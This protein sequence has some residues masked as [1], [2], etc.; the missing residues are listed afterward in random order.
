MNQF[1][2]KWLAEYNAKRAKNHLSPINHID[3]LKESEKPAQ[4][5]PDMKKLWHNTHYEKPLNF[6]WVRGI[7]FVVP[8]LP[9]SKPRQTQSDKW[10]QRPCVMR[11]REFA[12]RV[13][14][15]IKLEDPLVCGLNLIF[16]IPVK[17]S[18]SKEKRDQMI[19]KPHQ[20]RP[21]IDNY[22]KAVMDAL[23][24][25]DSIVWSISA[26]KFWCE[27]GMEMIEVNVFY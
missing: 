12:D 25:E 17:D 11:Y 8:G 6:A 19:G 1:D 22:T 24:S 7:Q 18:W 3:E 20:Q 26:K 21:D 5:K 9:V 4:A 16:H 14:E 2:S 27:P 13:R 23:L 10:K 15:W